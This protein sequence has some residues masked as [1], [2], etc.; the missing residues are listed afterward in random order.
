MIGTLK[1]E[2]RKSDKV[3][4]KNLLH[5]LDIQSIILLVLSAQSLVAFSIC[6]LT[7]HSSHH[8]ITGILPIVPVN[9]LVV[10]VDRI[11]IVPKRTKTIKTSLDSSLD[12]YLTLFYHRFSSFDWFIILTSLDI[13]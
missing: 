13:K 1:A 10:S 6:L 11:S 4:S 5:L 7:T 8:K 9:A 12:S 3:T 2:F